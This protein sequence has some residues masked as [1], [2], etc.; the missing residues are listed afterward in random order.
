MKKGLRKISADEMVKAIKQNDGCANAMRIWVQLKAQG[1]DTTYV[2]VR[3][4]ADEL[5]ASGIL[6]GQ[7]YETGT[8]Q[9]RRFW[10]V[11][12]VNPIEGH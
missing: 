1:V 7:G 6:T 11:K 4:R 3:K 8:G 10:R 12:D 9:R 5:E 2:T